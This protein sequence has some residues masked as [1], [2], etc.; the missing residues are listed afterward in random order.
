MYGLVTRLPAWMRLKAA[1]EPFHASSLRLA[2]ARLDSNGMVCTTTI[3]HDIDNR[4]LNLIY[5]G[6]KVCFLAGLVAWLHFAFFY[7]CV[8]HLSTRFASISLRFLLIRAPQR[9]KGGGG[10]NSKNISEF[11]VSRPEEAPGTEKICMLIRLRESLVN[12]R[13]WKT[14]SRPAH[15]NAM[16]FQSHFVRDS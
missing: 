13:K 16:N 2:H 5:F 12:V 4:R 14:Q 1:C 3:D 6:P 8:A 15:A 9:G 7:M 10:Q 11:H